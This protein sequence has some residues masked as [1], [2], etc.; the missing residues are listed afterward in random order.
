M[1]MIIFIGAQAAGKSSFY[2]LRFSDTHI[3]VNLDMLRTR[4]REQILVTACLKARQPFVVDNTNPTRLDRS[5]YIRLAKQYDCLISGFYFQSIARECLARN[6]LRDRSPLRDV[7]DAAIRNTIN[8]L[9]LPALEE[10]FD[11]LRFI[12]L[13]SRGFII[14]EWQDEV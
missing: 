4:N 8:R 9:E 2:K 13:T 10:G 14:E 11:Q 7:P 6:R 5:R 3:R 1:E 12:R